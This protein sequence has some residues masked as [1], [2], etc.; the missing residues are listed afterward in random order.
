MA[1]EAGVARGL[2]KGSWKPARRLVRRPRKELAPITHSHAPALLRAPDLPDLP[3]LRWDLVGKGFGRGGGCGGQEGRI[4]LLG[5]GPGVGRPSYA[6]ALEKHFCLPAIV[7]LN[8]QTAPRS[9]AQ[10]DG[11]KDPRSACVFQRK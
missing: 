4:T 10:L 9:A 2:G 7:R 6:S 3:D 1:F 5:L 11:L 8:L